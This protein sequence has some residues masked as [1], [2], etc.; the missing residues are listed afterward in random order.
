[1]LAMPA[2]LRA[3]LALSLLCAAF[4][5]QAARKTLTVEARTRIVDGGR[6]WYESRPYSFTFEIE[7]VSDREGPKPESRRQGQPFVTA[8]PGEE[9]RVRIHNPLPVPVAANLSIDGLNSITGD[10]GSPA[11][12]SKWVIEPFAWVDIAG[13]QVSN[14]QARRFVFTSR[15]RSYA[16]WRSN[17][18]GRDLSLNCG[19]IGVAYFWSQRA[20]DDYYHDNPVVISRPRWTPGS[21]GG[22]LESRSRS[23]MEPLGAPAGEAQ[24]RAGTGMGR[25]ESNPVRE[26]RFP[27]DRGMYEV[28]DALVVA[29][30]FPDEER[31]P[32]AFEEDDAYAP[33]PPRGRW[34]PPYFP[35][36]LP[37]RQPWR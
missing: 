14:R 26:V 27:C 21:P 4:P 24:Q 10:P 31:R 7:V 32:R 15:Q 9:Y 18:W 12:G 19:V 20:L 16:S 25:H 34:R 28:R 2:L 3:T 35:E 11:G 1:M 29:Y 22:G 8:F 17:D 5:A 13:W 6:K 36:R 23:T 37:G 30:D 33:E